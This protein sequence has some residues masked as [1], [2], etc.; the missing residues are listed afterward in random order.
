MTSNLGVITHKTYIQTNHI[1][2]AR[3][4]QVFKNR[5][6]IILTCTCLCQNV[7]CVKWTVSAIMGNRSKLQPLQYILFNF[8]PVIFFC[9]CIIR[10]LGITFRPWS[11]KQ[12]SVKSNNSSIWTTLS[13]SQNIAPV[14]KNPANKC[15][16]KYAIVT[17]IYICVRSQNLLD[18]LDIDSIDSARTNNH[19]IHKRYWHCPQSW[20][21]SYTAIAKLDV[22]R[23]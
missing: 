10:I 9:T 4:K 6:P 14:Y 1:P 13:L 8:Q 16:S 15:I 23:L 19:Q 12:T 22:I 17:R 2:V 11:S 21:C 18:W 20:H 3:A 7:C 5:T